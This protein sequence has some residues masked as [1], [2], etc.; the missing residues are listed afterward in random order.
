MEL[1]LEKPIDIKPKLK[2]TLQKDKDYED[3]IYKISFTTDKGYT[4]SMHLTHFPTNNC[5]LSSIGSFDNINFIDSKNKEDIHT[6]L[7]VIREKSCNQLMIDIYT[8]IVDEIMERI[9]P[10]FDIV[11][12]QDYI[13]T[14]T[15][16]MTIILLKWKK[17]I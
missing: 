1:K 2:V 6:L 12:K 13:S 5:Q 10:Y 11:F 3:Y 17:D 15:S 9:S 14:N 16:K 4:R 8:S 7:K